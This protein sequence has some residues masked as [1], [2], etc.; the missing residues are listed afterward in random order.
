MSSNVDS[1]GFAVDHD[2]VCL[3]DGVVDS[4]KAPFAVSGAVFQELFSGSGRDSPGSHLG[5]DP[6]SRERVFPSSHGGIP[7]ANDVT[8]EDYYSSDE[9][10]SPKSAS[11]LCKNE[12]SAT[13]HAL[14]RVSKH[15]RDE[16]YS[17]RKRL[18]DALRF[19]RNMGF[20]EA[21]ILA[22][23]SK[24]GFRSVQPLRDD[25]GLPIL[26]DSGLKPSPNPFVDKMKS[27]A[28]S[29]DDASLPPK[30]VLRD[31]H[32]VFEEC[33]KQAHTNLGAS[34][35]LPKDPGEF[36]PLP[37]ASGSLPKVDVEE[38]SSPTKIWSDVLKSSPPVANVKFEYCPPKEGSKL[39]DPPDE[40]LQEGLDKFK[41]C[42][43]G[44]FTKGTLSFG[45]VNEIAH[46]LWSKRG[47]V[48]VFQKN[49]NTF[50]F[51]FDGLPGK[52][53]VLARGT[54]HFNRRPL[55]L[56][57]W[58]VD[59]KEQPPSSMPIWVKFK[60]IPDC[61]WTCEGLS[62]IA[63]VIGKPL[64]ADKLTSQLDILPF[65][66]MCVDYKLGDDLP[67]SIP[68]KVLDNAGNHSVVDIQVD[69][70]NKPI[71]CT[72]CKAI[73]HSVAAC[74]ITRRVWVRKQPSASPP[75]VPQ[76]CPMAPD[77]CAPANIPVKLANSP[78]KGP[79]PNLA[80][81]HEDE[82]HNWQDVP[83]KHCFSNK[84]QPR[85]S[86]KA[87]V[88]H[89]DESPPVSEA[90]KNL[91]KVDELDQSPGPKLSKAQKKRLKRSSEK[92]PP[93]S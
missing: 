57:D 60:E 53:M 6:L 51:K 72:G 13:I 76:D 47:L 87:S 17:T 29:V 89:M 43:I 50:V 62:R 26:N 46:K 66:C 33:P 91:R 9:P 58:G 38:K 67:S 42:I 88:V 8:V 25:F 61:Y 84:Q 30:F 19:L 40:I 12:S 86:G 45:A 90:F 77:H 82:N 56:S 20:S 44:V 14:M 74:P 27:K 37:K 10:L 28:S 2:G 32:E 75:V 24:D 85:G 3:E 64:C 81:G 22:A 23:Q 73:G 11:E 16:L 80:S 4:R 1:R 52:S 92:V 71:L 78:L 21:Q 15:E 34:V 49:E 41:L 83:K 31:A 65:A 7:I 39:V 93:P 55:V 35:N 69:Y 5:S 63:S 70:V 79:G 36:P 68:V 54:W 18:A 59:I 48:K